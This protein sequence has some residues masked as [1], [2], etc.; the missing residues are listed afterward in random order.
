MLIHM[1]IKGV[2][3]YI[4]LLSVMVLCL[5]GCAG[6][7]KVKDIGV[8]DFKVEGVSA[9]G[10]RSLTVNFVVE[11]DNPAPQLSFRNVYGTLEHSG[12][13]LGRVAVD[14]FTLQGKMVGKY[15]LKADVTLG[16]GATLFE[17]RKLLDKSVVDECVVDL[18]A[19]VKIKNGSPKKLGLENIPLKEILKT[20]K[21]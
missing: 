2:K 4:L 18:E 17:L 19:E 16:E 1:N 7:S 10:M 8:N 12:K 21:K 15:H 14:P 6:I 13:I 3:R 11:V 5:S 9:N 20:V